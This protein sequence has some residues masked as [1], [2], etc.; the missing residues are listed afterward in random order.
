MNGRPAATAIRVFL[1]G[2]VMTGRGV[3][4][5][6]PDPTDPVL[7][8]S[9]VKSAATYVELAERAHGRIP[10]N[11][12]PGYVWGRALEEF[13]RLRPDARIVN[14]ET[15]VT[16]DGAPAPK[17]INYRMSPGNVGCLTAAG[18]DCCGL[19]NNH[20]LDWGA[21]GLLDT[22]STLGRAGIK[23]AGAGRNDRE[24]R[25]P[26][27]LDVA[28]KGRLLIY[29][30]AFES[31]GV[32][33]GWRATAARPGVNVFDECSQDAAM[34]I[35]RDIGR[36][37]RPGDVV[38]VSAHWGPNWGYEIPQ[39]HVDFAR[40]LTESVG[41]SVVHGHSSHHAIALQMRAG[42]AILYGCGDFLN[43]Y[44]GIGGYE[45]FR[46]DL[47]LMY[48]LDIDPASGQIVA[49][50]IAPLTIKR[51]SLAAATQADVAWIAE[52]LTRESE[53]FGLAVVRGSDGALGLSTKD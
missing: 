8:E 43:D 36:A 31:S 46:G 16:R 32:P 6:L 40:A 34:E 50:E 29:A 45:E 24:A 39:A 30:C 2:D 22:L 49:A 23:T 10:R 26:V 5:I 52:R 38:I 25:A 27:I 15:S 28:G 35:A 17:G 14:L 47:S 3:D 12:D 42:R 37:R 19:A 9:Y 18:I 41:V 20:V 11:A 48:F 44:E 13:A 4:Q 51:M 1:C 21:S 33:R 7:Y 53:R